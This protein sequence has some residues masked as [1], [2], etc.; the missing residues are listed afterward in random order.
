MRAGRITVAAA[1]LAAA[2]LASCGGDEGQIYSPEETASC[3][4][5]VGARVS[6]RDADVVARGA[7]GYQVAIAGKTLNIAFGEDVGD[8]EQILAAY[9]GAGG[10]AEL[11]R[12]GNA[13]LSWDDEPGREWAAVEGCLRPG[14][15]GARPS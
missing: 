7:R 4:V 8:A 13:M 15:R 10:N 2:A 3:L 11:Y 6:R 9:E 14:G 5:D 1:S 12:E